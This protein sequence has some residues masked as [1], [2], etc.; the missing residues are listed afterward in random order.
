MKLTIK[1]LKQVEYPIELDNDDIDI[2]SL[3]LK[4]Q[5]KHGFEADKMKL[6]YQ[7]LILTNEKKIKEYGIEDG[8][9]II[10]MG[11]KLKIENK[12]K[13]E[14]TKKDVSNTNNTAATN[15]PN[16]ITNTNPQTQTQTQTKPEPDYSKEI[17]QL[18]DLGIARDVAE[19]VIKAAKGNVNIAV[20]Y[21]FNGIPENLPS[22]NFPGDL[23]AAA[24]DPFKMIVS[25]VK[26]IGSQNPSAI[27]GI[28]GTIQ[29]TDPNLFEA[30]KAREDEFRNALAEPITDEDNRNYEIFTQQMMSGGVP[31]DGMGPGVGRQQPRGRGG[32]QVSRE[33]Y[34]AIQRLKELGFSEID[35]VQA[36]RAFQGNEEMYAL[37]FFII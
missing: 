4:I 6:L 3:K 24:Q 23:G 28:L 16:P 30:I 11:S 25:V 12:P 10:M 37:F 7:G 20:E 1:T 5:E 8:C 18:L 36:Y 31:A 15:I 9:V 32:I 14:D 22:D 21:A 17:S 35:C 29:Q 34:N 27:Q 13:P 33:E 26:I 19:N 2:Q